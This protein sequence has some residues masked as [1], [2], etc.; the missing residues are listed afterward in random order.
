MGLPTTTVASFAPLLNSPSFPS[1]YTSL[2]SRSIY[3]LIQANLVASAQIAAPKTT[4][5]TIT[6]PS[7]TAI[8]ASATQGVVTVEHEPVDYTFESAF[9]T[10]GHLETFISEL[11]SGT[12]L[13]PSAFEPLV[14]TEALRTATA[15][16]QVVG[17]PFLH[18]FTGHA[19]GT[20][21]TTDPGG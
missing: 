13:S 20:L 8:V 2:V 10:D 11:S 4:M 15:A 17:T 14:E 5:L 18:R 3:G 1:C 16:S 6:A 21:P 9:I 7:G 19:N 12:T